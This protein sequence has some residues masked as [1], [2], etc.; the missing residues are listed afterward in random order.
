LTWSPD[1]TNI[2]VI[3]P[4]TCGL[5]T[6]DW[7][8]FSTDKY[9]VV[10]GMRTDCAT[11]TCTGMAGGPPAPGPPAEVFCPHPVTISGATASRISADLGH[12]FVLLKEAGMVDRVSPG[13]NDKFYDTFPCPPRR[14][15]ERAS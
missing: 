10:S 7:R 3:C 14:K 4:S 5:I 12:L 13:H 8:D 6:A 2:L 9:S 15:T 1:F 11:C